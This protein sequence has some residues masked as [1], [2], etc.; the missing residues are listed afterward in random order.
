MVSGTLVISSNVSEISEIFIDGEKI[1]NH[2][3]CYIHVGNP[4]TNEQQYRI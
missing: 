4:T 2:G 1:R 3:V